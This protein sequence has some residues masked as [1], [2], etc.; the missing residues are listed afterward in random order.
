MISRSDVD[1]LRPSDKMQPER[2]SMYKLCRY[3]ES[4]EGDPSE[5]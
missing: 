1:R 5:P 2:A 3:Y 4:L